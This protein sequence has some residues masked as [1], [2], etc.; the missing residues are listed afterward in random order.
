MGGVV[1]LRRPRTEMNG[2]ADGHVPPIFVSHGT[3]VARRSTPCAA[4]ELAQWARDLAAPAWRSSSSALTGRRPRSRAAPRPR[5]RPLLHDFDGYPVSSS[6]PASCSASRSAR[7]A[8]PSSPT[9]CTQLLPVER[10]PERGWDQRRLDAARPHVPGGDVP[11]LQLSLVARG[12]AAQPLRDRSQDRRPRFA[13]RPR[14]SAAAAITHKLAEMDPATR[15][16]A[17]PTGRASSTAGSRTSSPTRS[18]TTSCNGAAK[19]PNARR[20]HPTP[21]HLDPLF[22]VAGAASLYDHAVGFPSAASS[23]ARSVAAAFS[24]DARPRDSAPQRDSPGFPHRSPVRHAARRWIVSTGLLQLS[25]RIVSTHLVERARIDAARALARVE[26]GAHPRADA[27]ASRPHSRRSA[28][29]TRCCCM[30]S[31]ARS[32]LRRCGRRRARSRGDRPRRR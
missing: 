15:G 5:A 7:P 25:V 10:A 29:R 23:T 13:R 9:S 26:I 21:E 2:G 14:S 19:G 30:R 16:I 8:R 1:A 27:R 12:D 20:A 6:S 18:S 28:C 24:S 32:G 11:V 4:A 31:R 3:P 17:V 22:V